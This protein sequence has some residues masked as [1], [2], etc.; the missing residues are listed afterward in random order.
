MKGASKGREGGRR[1]QTR[2]RLSLFCG[3]LCVYWIPRASRT[4]CLYSIRADGDTESG[5]ETCCGTRSVY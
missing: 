4:R 2:A 3:T 1:G 5:L